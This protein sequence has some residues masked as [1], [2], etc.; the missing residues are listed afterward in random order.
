MKSATYHTHFLSEKSSETEGI[1]DY[2]ERLLKSDAPPFFI[3]HLNVCSRW[4]TQKS[5]LS[6]DDDDEEEPELDE[7]SFS[8]GSFFQQI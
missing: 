8:T 6:S 2:S 1:K 5:S 3:D 4:S 7:D